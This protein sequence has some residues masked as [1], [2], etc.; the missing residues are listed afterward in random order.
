MKPHPNTQRLVFAIMASAWSVAVPAQEALPGRNVESLLELAQTRNPE[1][2]GMRY[3][4]EAA[5]ERVTSAD[6]LPDPRFRAELRDITRMGEQDPTLAP[7]G[8]GSTRYLITQDVP[9]FGKR[10]L[11]RH[12][13]EFEA[14][15]ARKKTDGT[16]ADLAAQ[17][18][19]AH[20]QRY[21]LSRTE[22]LTR[23]ILDLMI[24]LEKVAQ[25]RYA[26]GLAAQQDVIRAQVEQTNLQ[27]ELLTLESERRQVNARL[28]ALLARPASAPLA[29]PKELRPLPAPA[30]LDETDLERRVRAYN[31]SLS[32]E[33]ASVNAAEQE[34]ELTD[35]NR[36]PD[37]T[38]GG[39]PIQYQ[40][41]IKEWELMVEVNIPFPR[42]SR[43]AQE[44]ESVARLSAA[45]SREETTANQVLAELS[46]NLAGLDAARRTERLMAT[47]LLPQAE[48]TFHAALA[49]YETGRV[50]FATLLESQRQ[51][52]Q[53]KQN[54]IK[55]QTD[56]QMRLATIE[57][58]IGEDL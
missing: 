15:G 56:A 28:N 32:A 1:Y 40:D 13:A 17:I 4:A 57:K 27:T 3:E 30:A 53:A 5:A 35:K 31:P 2:A 22:Q 9:W 55:A 20:A 54:Q 42:P 45:K 21:D 25:V 6:A 37:F 18:K 23:E 52:R 46:E 16:W 36:Y 24:R 8:V 14:E 43:R 38:L 33:H 58:L 11:K 29:E 49:G 48:L 7:N 34:R 51:I 39:G 10:A 26:S 50:D 19:T 47:N 12:I 44:R 41:A